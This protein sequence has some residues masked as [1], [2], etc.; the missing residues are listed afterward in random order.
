MG[1]V[2]PIALFFVALEGVVVAV[3]IVGS[4]FYVKKRVASARRW[5]WCM[6]LVLVSA[7]FPILLSVLG[8][9]DGIVSNGDVLKPLLL[10]IAAIVPVGIM[11]LMLV[12]KRESRGPDDAGWKMRSL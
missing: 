4:W 1:L 10:C 8:I 12:V 7:I 3:S 2:F 6:I 11:W 5:R 9:V